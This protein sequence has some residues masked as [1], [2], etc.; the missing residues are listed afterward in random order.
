MALLHKQLG[1]HSSVCLCVSRA[2]FL[3]SR[4]LSAFFRPRGKPDLYLELLRESGWGVGLGYLRP[5]YRNQSMARSQGCGGSVL[6]PVRSCQRQ[7]PRH[8]IEHSC[9]LG[10][11]RG[12]K[13]WAEPF[14]L[15]FSLSLFPK[16]L[17][18]QAETKSKLR[19]DSQCTGDVRHPL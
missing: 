6:P 18:E 17:S 19:A 2:V 12:S 16:R 1:P 13:G 8:G 7:M 9:S 11:A 5:P 4:V 3:F 14:V 10:R 15:P